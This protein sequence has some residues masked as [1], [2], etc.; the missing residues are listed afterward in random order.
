LAIIV[1]SQVKSVILVATALVSR[2]LPA[3]LQLGQGDAHAPGSSGPATPT[4]RRHT[5]ASTT[6]LPVGPG[7][8][9]DRPWW[10]SI[11]KTDRSRVTRDSV[12][13]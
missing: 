10:R 6:G 11:E 4:W 7:D 8:R 13:G 1:A 5:E 2:V 12:S 9:P 3:L